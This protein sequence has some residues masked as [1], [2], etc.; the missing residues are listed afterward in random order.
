MIWLV[1]LARW[2]ASGDCI[3]SVTPDHHTN[4]DTLPDVKTLQNPPA[5]CKG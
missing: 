3:M 2:L 4:T 5:A 1:W